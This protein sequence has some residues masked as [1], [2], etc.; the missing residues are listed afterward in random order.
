MRVLDQNVVDK[1]DVRRMSEPQLTKLGVQL[2]DRN[3][4]S[5]RC[6]ACGH[7]WAPQLDCDGKLG[8]T[9]WLC[10]ASCNR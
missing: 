3:E 9:Y 2:V 8:F 1:E 4:L 6:L 10:P 7:I 5:L